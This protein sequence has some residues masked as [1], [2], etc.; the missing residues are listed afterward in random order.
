M[1]SHKFTVGQKVELVRGHGESHI[2]P[3]VY[4]VVRQLPAEAND[5][6]YQIKSVDDGHQRVVRE[7]QLVG[8]SAVS[9]GN[10]TIQGG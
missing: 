3:G 6:Q 1:P 4:T 8:T 10:A 5:Y 9:W 2:P 7:S